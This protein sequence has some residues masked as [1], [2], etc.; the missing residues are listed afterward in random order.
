MLANVNLKMVG[1]WIQY[2][3]VGCYRWTKADNTWEKKRLFHLMANTSILTGNCTG[4]TQS[5][6]AVKLNVAGPI[7]IINK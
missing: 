2:R 4:K 5:W 6:K 3:Q 1:R 7:T